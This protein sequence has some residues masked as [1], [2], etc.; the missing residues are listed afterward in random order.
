MFKNL[1]LKIVGNDKEEN[2]WF[3]GM[4]DKSYTAPSRMRGD[5]LLF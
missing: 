3:F 5:S 1:Y 4:L 2:L